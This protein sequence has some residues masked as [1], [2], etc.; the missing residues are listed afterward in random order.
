[1]VTC[2]YA[3][4]ARHYGTAIWRAPSSE[5][6]DKSKVEVGVQ[7]VGRWILARLRNH[8]FFALSAL[9][10]AIR[11]LPVD[12]QQGSRIEARVAGVLLGFGMT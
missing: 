10:E 9:N 11:D 2:T 8:R 6:K 3:D 12:L 5:P 7:I 1:M 4:L